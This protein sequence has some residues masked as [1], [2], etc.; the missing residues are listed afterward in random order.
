MVSSYW[1]AQLI[2]MNSSQPIY[3]SLYC[4][5]ADCSSLAIDILLLPG[6]TALSI[7]RLFS[8]NKDEVQYIVG[9]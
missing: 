7:F 5:H 6:V 1:L 9:L 8:N 2:W 3:P 4:K